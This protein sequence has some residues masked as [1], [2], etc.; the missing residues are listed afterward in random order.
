MAGFNVNLSDMRTRVTFQVPTISKD[1]GGAQVE[2]WAN[3]TSNPTVWARWTNA[4][5]QEAVQNEALKSSQR[6][7]VVVRYRTDILTTWQVLKDSEAWQIISIDEVQDRN[8]WVELVVERV[9]GTA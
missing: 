5:G 1:A 4:H 9:K 2:T 6:A 8:R 7:A 3:V